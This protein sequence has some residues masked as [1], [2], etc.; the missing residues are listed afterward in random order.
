MYDFNEVEDMCFDD[1]EEYG[2]SHPN[3]QAAVGGVSADTV[4]QKG[5]KTS[6]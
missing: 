4:G 1:A 6:L 3:Q 2:I 5:I